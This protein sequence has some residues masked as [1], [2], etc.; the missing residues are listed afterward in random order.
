MK[1]LLTVLA[2]TDIGVLARD[3]LAIGAIVEDEEPVP[4]G[5]HEMVVYVEG[6]QDL[7]SRLTETNVEVRGVD[8]N[9]E[10]GFFASTG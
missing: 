7:P 10:L 4:I 2:D 8:P 1:W 9:S 3:L 5:D 6:P